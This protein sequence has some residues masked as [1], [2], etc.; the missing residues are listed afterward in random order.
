LR[1]SHLTEA[2][3]YARLGDKPTPSSKSRKSHPALLP[4]I[5]T[6]LGK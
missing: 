5:F 4:Q 3:S 6:K 2:P 1:M